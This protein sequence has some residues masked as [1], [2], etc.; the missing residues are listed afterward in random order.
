M[1]EHE[2]GLFQT[3]SADVHA[4]RTVFT[5]VE[6]VTAGAF[7]HCTH[8]DE[9]RHVPFRDETLGVPGRWLIMHPLTHEFHHGGQM[10]TVGRMLGHPYLPG[11]WPGLSRT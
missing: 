10:L 1:L 6:R 11:H 3:P 9:P 5:G 2:P 7:E 4:M 8:P